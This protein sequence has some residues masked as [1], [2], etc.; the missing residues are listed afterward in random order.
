MH[1]SRSAQQTPK[2]KGV[3]GQ[4]GFSGSL[5]SL[6]HFLFAMFTHSD[7]ILTTEDQLSNS[8]E[9]KSVIANKTRPCPRDL[10]LTQGMT[11]LKS[12]FLQHQDVFLLP[13]TNH[14]PTPAPTSQEELAKGD[15]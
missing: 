10:C 13:F 15:F 3:L 6:R 5:D 7:L 1:Y 14:K 8:L 11:K 2:N 9:N 4:D 12:L